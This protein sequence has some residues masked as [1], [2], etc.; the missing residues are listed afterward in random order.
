MIPRKPLAGKR[1]MA[2]G[3]PPVITMPNGAKAKIGFPRSDGW[4]PLS[5]KGKSANSNNQK[6]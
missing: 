3:K 2:P 5:I 4:V 1:V 6:K